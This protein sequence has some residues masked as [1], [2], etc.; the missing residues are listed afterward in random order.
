MPAGPIADAPDRHRPLQG[1]THG[2]LEAIAELVSLCGARAGEARSNSV[3]ERNMRIWI[4]AGV[5]LLLVSM[6]METDS[7]TAATTDR[8]PSRSE[9][10]CRTA[11]QS[12]CGHVRPGV[13]SIMRCLEAKQSQMSTECRQLFDGG[14]T[15]RLEAIAEACTPEV[16]RLC[17]HTSDEAELERCAVERIRDLSPS[18][19]ERLTLLPVELCR[20]D[21]ARL[22]SSDPEVTRPLAACIEIHRKALTE[23]CGSTLH[24]P[25]AFRF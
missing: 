4:Q 24:L 3:P 8:M 1:E 17:G 7:T 16:R 25:P 13:G 23:A 11:L 21:V 14:V 9:W 10:S 2:S 5:I 22:C 18:C 15:S 12:F 6:P 20:T 19:K